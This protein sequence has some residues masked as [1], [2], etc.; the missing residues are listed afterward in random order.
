MASSL[1]TLYPS[2]APSLLSTLAILESWP[3]TKTWAKQ[4]PNTYMDGL[5][6]GF[7]MYDADTK[8]LV[9]VLGAK[10]VEEVIPIVGDAEREIE[11]KEWDD[12]REC[13]V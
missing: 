9:A 5:D 6:Q 11:G 8:A 3:D 10:A 4:N 2:I 12:E 13:W 7:G 1:Q